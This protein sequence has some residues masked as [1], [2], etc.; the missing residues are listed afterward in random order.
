MS[1]PVTNECVSCGVQ[2]M[3]SE[4]LVVDEEN[5]H[6]HDGFWQVDF[7]CLM[8]WLGGLSFKRQVRDREEM[9]TYA[10]AGQ[11]WPVEKGADSAGE[12]FAHGPSVNT[13]R[14]PVARGWNHKVGDWPAHSSP[15]HDKKG[16][17]GGC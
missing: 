8:A 1:G 3:A 15:L 17:D 9:T 2:R 11:R 14:K 5:I 6:I 13:V 16:S 4:G 12:L 7:N 10:K